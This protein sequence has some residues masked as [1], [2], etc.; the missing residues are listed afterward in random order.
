MRWGHLLVELPVPDVDLDEVRRV[1]DG[2]LARPE[3]R[4][5][6]PGLLRRALD[7]VLEWL[8]RILEAVVGAGRQNV[9]G[10][11]VVLVVLGVALILLVRFLRGVR[12]D[13]G[14]DRALDLAPGRSPR[15]W[16]AE[17]EEQERAGR[18]REA[19]RCRYRLLL[20]RL[21]ARGL[22]EEVPGRTSGEYLREATEAL[23]AAAGDLWTVTRAFERAWYGNQPVDADEVHRVA[24]AV[25]R[26]ET[27]ALTGASR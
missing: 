18:W 25:D 26:V 5:N 16:Q 1:T 22:I 17:A 21:A 8:G 7:L 11:I 12:R 13:P 9:V 3:Y 19:L 23:P 15:E 6:E 14:K 24:D 20:A 27:P 10:T 2:V 4:E